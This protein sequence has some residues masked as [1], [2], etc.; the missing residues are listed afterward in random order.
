[1]VA[2]GLE[3]KRRSVLHLAS[4]RDI[5]VAKIQAQR[6]PFHRLSLPAPRGGEGPARGSSGRQEQTQRSTSTGAPTPTLRPLRKGVPCTNGTACP[7]RPGTAVR[8]SQIGANPETA[9]AEQ[10]YPSKR[11]SMPA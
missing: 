10:R 3:C 9:E 6:I 1:E 4:Q 5:E 11:K 2:D 7:S 8:Q